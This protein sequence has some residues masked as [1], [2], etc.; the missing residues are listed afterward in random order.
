M[1]MQPIL[2]AQRCNTP[3]VDF[4]DPGTHRTIN[5]S[6][7]MAEQNNLLVQ[8]NYNKSV[9]DSEQN[10]KAPLLNQAVPPE[11]R[12]ILNAVGTR[13]FQTTDSPQDILEK[14][15]VIYG[16]LSPMEGMH[17]ENKWAELWNP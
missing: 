17:M 2:Y 6:M 15:R 5:P 1:S 16:S 3:W 11:Y 9:Y 8:Y 7:N 13:E 10:I 14:L 12:R 4:V